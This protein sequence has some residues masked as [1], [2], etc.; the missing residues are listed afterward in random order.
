DIAEQLSHAACAVQRG[1]HV[2]TVAVEQVARRDRLGSV[3]SGG[4]VFPLELGGQARTGPARVGVTFEAADVHHGRIGVER[5][6]PVQ[7][8]FGPALAVAFPV[9]RRV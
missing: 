7:G 5:R 8:R 3:F 6:A 9:E 4:G 2:P 1:A